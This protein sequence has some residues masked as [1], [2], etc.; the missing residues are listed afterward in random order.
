MRIGAWKAAGLLPEGTRG[1]RFYLLGDWPMRVG[2][3]NVVI[4]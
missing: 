1:A 3:W 2:E 4:R